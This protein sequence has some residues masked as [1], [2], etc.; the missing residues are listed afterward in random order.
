MGM[1]AVK[2]L[3]H[4]EYR[5]SCDDIVEANPRTASNRANTTS[6]RPHSV[7]ALSP[8]H[9]DTAKTPQAVRA[10]HQ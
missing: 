1:N 5:V 10:L 9:T 4:R 2:D 8:S 7:A 6:D 3:S